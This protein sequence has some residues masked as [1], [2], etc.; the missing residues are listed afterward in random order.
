MLAASE[1]LRTHAGRVKSFG[2]GI[3]RR[4]SRKK[5]L[6]TKNSTK[7]ELTG[8]TECVQFQIWLVVL[9]QAQGWTASLS[10]EHV[11]K[12]RRDSTTRRLI[13]M[14]IRDRDDKV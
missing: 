5:T 11:E 13:H 4:K 7:I 3:A 2:H 9:A 1:N 12:S 14:S 10:V 6:N 8:T